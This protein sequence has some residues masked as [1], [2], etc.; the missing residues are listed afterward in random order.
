[1]NKIIIALTLSLL[2]TSAFAGDRLYH[3]RS[4]NGNAVTTRCSDSYYNGT[5][6]TTSASAF[7]GSSAQIISVPDYVPNTNPDWGKNCRS[8]DA[9]LT[10]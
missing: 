6:C 3:W 8:C 2:S 5:T 7:G 10:K 4:Y 9:S 1:M